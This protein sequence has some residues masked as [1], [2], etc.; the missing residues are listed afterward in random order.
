[1]DDLRAPGLGRWMLLILVV[2]VLGQLLMVIAGTAP[3]DVVLILI[4][5]EML[6]A[7]VVAFLWRQDLE[8]LRCVVTGE[9]TDP[10]RLPE[11]ERVGTFL[12]QAVIR[13]RERLALLEVQLGA[14][15]AIL[16][17][18]PEPLLLVTA[19][20]TVQRTNEAARQTVGADTAAVLR[21]PLL[22]GAID[23]ALATST[24]QAADLLFA[25]P[26]TREIHA[27]VT[28]L[29]A[30]LFEER[31]V[32]VLLVDHTRERAVE[33][34][35]ADFVAN[36]SHELRTPLASLIG[37][38]ETLQGPAKDDLPA[39]ERFLDIM[40]QQAA[41]MN[42]LIDD[43]LSLSRIELSEHQPPQGKIQFS[44]L[45]ERTL[46]AFEPRIVA[47]GVRLDLR[48]ADLPPV[49]GDVDQMAQVLSNLF[50]NALKYGREGG[51]ITLTVEAVAGLPW[52]TRPGVVMVVAD[53]GAGIPKAHLPRLTERFY[54]VDKGRSRAVGGTGLGLAIVKHIVNRHRGQLTIT[55]EEG[56]GTRFS[57]WLPR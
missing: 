23:R 38:V 36:A 17:H 41:R 11:I 37:F 42:R 12:G 16:E 4:L 1:M 34:M 28:P 3:L 18:L 24:P 43:L 52:P 22:R 53:D 21:H 35:R 8:R 19:D 46:A 26:V 40:A 33:R 7:M 57:V 55:S 15:Q 10:P 20:G 56:Q 50:D 9:P 45:I 44:E 2:P 47:R 13:T 29:D 51:V 5:V 48:L 32:S 49:A 30:G 14:E 25:A 39:R 6:A 54:R 27:M 31:H